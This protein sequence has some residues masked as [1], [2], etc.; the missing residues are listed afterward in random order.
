[1][2]TTINAS[3][4]TIF[5]KILV[6]IDGSDEKPNLVCYP[7]RAGPICCVRSTGFCTQMSR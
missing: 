6:A 3:Q 7:D 2:S 5:S 1:M 4:N